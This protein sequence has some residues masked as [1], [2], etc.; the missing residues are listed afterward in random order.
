MKQIFENYVLAK[1]NLLFIEIPG[2]QNKY[3]ILIMG[4]VCLFTKTCNFYI[5]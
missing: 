3:S 2:N 4:E 5:F 1:I